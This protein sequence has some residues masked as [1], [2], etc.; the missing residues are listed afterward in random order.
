MFPLLT[1][2]TSQKKHCHT[3]QSTTTP[4]EYNAMK[5]SAEV[6]EAPAAAEA[7][8]PQAADVNNKACT[9]AFQQLLLNL[10]WTHKIPWSHCT[11]SKVAIF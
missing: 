9:A 7:K 8:G 3:A 1:I 5:F 6:S 2:I 11:A 10:P 4:S